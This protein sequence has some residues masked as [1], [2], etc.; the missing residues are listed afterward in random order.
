MFE[1]FTTQARHVV[2]LAG[3]EARALDHSYIGTEH[4]LLGLLGE[5]DGIAARAL[6]E[7]DLSLETAR[8]RVVAA[9]GRGN[10]PA[11]GH[12]PFTP[13]AKKLMDLSQREA[14]SLRH[15]HVGTE[16]I[17]L[18]TLKLGEGLAATVLNE[19][20]VNSRELR[21]RVV[22]L[23]AEAEADRMTGLLGQTGPRQGPSADSDTGV[24]DVAEPR[25]TAAAVAGLS[26]AGGYAGQDPVGS[27]HLL[28]AL[29]GDPSSAATRTLTSLG[30]DLAAAR[31]ALLRADLT[32]TSDEVPETAGRR[33]MSLRLTDSALVLEATDRRLI[34]LA[35]LAFGE[36]GRHRASARPESAAGDDDAASD[37]DTPAVELLLDG[38]DPV[39]ASL[40]A[41][42]KVLEASLKDIRSRAAAQ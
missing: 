14:F 13:R 37:S 42:W 12:M 20:R 16:H 36:V 4:L 11:Q 2:S 9:I 15:N 30:L 5:T 29:L 21:A 8:S 22:A 34:G 19:W 28:L 33:G 41:V 31:D 27:H 7:V 18:G 23:I 25:R 3:D 39:A 1:R 24:L 38:R 10:Q 17:L 35:R 26:A 40:A 6:A 32:D